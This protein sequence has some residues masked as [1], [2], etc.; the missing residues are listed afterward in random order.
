MCVVY[1]CDKWYGCGVCDV[2]YCG[3]YVVCVCVLYLLCVRNVW[4]GMVCVYV[5]GGMCVC[6]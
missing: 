4:C 2:C 5:H 1:V 3:E 6:V